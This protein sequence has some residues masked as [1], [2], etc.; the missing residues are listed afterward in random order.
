[1]AM[2][3]RGASGSSTILDNAAKSKRKN[4]QGSPASMRIANAL[5]QSAGLSRSAKRSHANGRSRSHA[6]D[7]SKRLNPDPDS[8]SSPPALE[9]EADPS[10]T[11][12]NVAN[13][14]E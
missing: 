10:M 4:L 5:R 11:S 6:N 7:D 2:G 3:R 12:D 8:S 1:M 9:T 14:V 13:Q